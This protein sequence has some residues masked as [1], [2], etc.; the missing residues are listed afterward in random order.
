MSEACR[1]DYLG[2]AGVRLVGGEGEERR[3]LLFD[4]FYQPG[5]FGGK[6][7]ETRLTKPLAPLQEAL[8]ADALF[9]S[10]AHA[11]H[12]DEEFFFRFYEAA[13]ARGESEKVRAFLPP[14]VCDWV[15]TRASQRPGCEA[16]SVGATYELGS[17][18]VKA[19]D[20]R[21][22]DVHGRVSRFCFLVTNSEGRS[23]LVT[24]DN[25]YPPEGAPCELD[26]LIIWPFKQPLERFAERVRPRVIMLFHGD[27]F[28]PG[29]FF[30][31]VNWPEAREL[32]RE[33]FPEANIIT[34]ED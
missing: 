32:T 26:T 11:D 7:C 23:I 28:S 33:I 21:G 25:H 30:C 18:R 27:H 9:V 16:L 4:P 20:N 2:H 1:I 29:D 24:G 34:P 15:N 17:F 19:L 22:L 10:H 6:R 5:S 31:N 3:T 12:F 8:I 13:V 14:E